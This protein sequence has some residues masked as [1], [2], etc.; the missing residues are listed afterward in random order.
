[1]TTKATHKSS[2]PI[3][4]KIF[5]NFLAVEI[6]K[7]KFLA[8][9]CPKILENFQKINFIPANE[10]LQQYQI[11]LFAL[12]ILYA[13]IWPLFQYETKNYLKMTWG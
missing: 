4:R 6:F 5:P 10:A 8:W 1:M 13:H 7:E 9:N 11:K 3:E 12:V 2:Y